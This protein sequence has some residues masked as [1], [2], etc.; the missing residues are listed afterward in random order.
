MTAK[1][2]G[3]ETKY[4][5]VIAAS[6]PVLPLSYSRW[7]F[8]PTITASSTIIPITNRKANREITF[9]EISIPGRN[10]KEPV[11]AVPIPIEHQIATAGRRKSINMKNTKIR[12][13]YA[14]LIIRFILPL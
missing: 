12:P 9:N 7:I 8:S 4:A 5:P 14:A 6:V 10:I 2:T 13:P 11:N 3:F 1:N